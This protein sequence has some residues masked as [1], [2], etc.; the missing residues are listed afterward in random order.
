MLCA[1]IKQY[2]ENTH[3]K[4]HSSYKLELLQVFQVKRDVEEERFQPVRTSPTPLPLLFMAPWN[5]C[6]FCEGQ[7]FVIYM[8]SL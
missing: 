6:K 2:M 5:S 7:I 3:A 4:T 8:H 1:Q